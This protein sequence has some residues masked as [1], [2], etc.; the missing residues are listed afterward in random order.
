MSSFF[1]WTETTI[2]RLRH[3]WAGPDSTIAIGVKLGVSKN[4]VVGKAHRIGL[5][6]RPSPIERRLAAPAGKSRR[7]RRI[8]P[9]PKNSLPRLASLP[10][11]PASPAAPIAAPVAAQAPAVS[12]V[13]PDPPRAVETPPLIVYAPGG[14]GCEAVLSPG[15]RAWTRGTSIAAS[16]G[17]IAGAP[18]ARRT[19]R[20]SSRDA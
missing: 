12:L 11:A 1:D 2:A 16:R 5:P 18:T 20:C 17:A 6:S 14:R 4:A 15:V 8:V 3:L 10:A 7:A 13:R 9:E 19:R